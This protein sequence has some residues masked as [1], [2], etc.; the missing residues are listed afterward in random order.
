MYKAIASL[1][2]CLIAS[3]ANAQTTD[4]IYKTQPFGKIDI[5]DLQM[6]TC[7]FEKDANA[8][9]L[10]SKSNVYFNANY[11]IVVEI[12]KRI[13]IFNDNGKDYANVRIEYYG[14]DRSEFISGIQGETI[15]LVNGVPEFTKVDKKQIFSEK[16]DR[17]KSA[18]VFSFPNVKPGSILEYKYTI[19]GNNIGNFPDWYFQTSIPT[20]YS[21]LT[22]NIPDILYY[23]NLESVHQKFVVNKSNSDGSTTKALANVASI[24]D[25]PYMSSL[26]DNCQRI[27][28]QLMSVRP[29]GQRVMTFSDSWKKVGETLI[30]SESFGMQLNRK[31]TGEEA[32]IAKAKALKTDDEKIAYLFNEVKNSMKW[33]EYY[34]KYPEDG[35]GKAWDKKAGNSGEIN[36]ILYH[37]LKKSGVM[38]FPM[39]TSTRKNGRVNPAYPNYY[40]FNNTVAYVPVDSA[41]YYVL[42]ASNK[43]N[44]YNQIPANLL[45]SFGFYM[46]KDQKDYDIKFLQNTTP[47]RQVVLLNGTIKPDG[48]MS[49]TAEVSNFGYNRVAVVTKYK[50]DG[51]KKFMDYL[52]NDD[53]NLKISSIK[54]DGIDVDTLPLTHKV[55]FDLDLTGSDDKYIYFSPNMLSSVKLNP[56]LAENRYTDIDFG[57][58][59][60]YYINCTF[61]VPAGFKVDVLPKNATMSL[62]DKSMSFKRIAAEEDGTIVIRFIIDQKKSIYFKENYEEFHEFYKKMYEMLNEQIVLKKS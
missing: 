11:D 32:I 10:F 9:F 39:I 23:K 35:I 58:R 59:S 55:A 42:D 50:K 30:E 7:D 18:T 12:H 53:N 27:L 3:F 44:I 31:I 56:F 26:E 15:N 13:K 8:E 38:V 21:E 51:E 48:K 62:A 16:I 19:V 33:N 41:K 46:N 52:V 28:F 20:R 61:K 49:G 57:Y 4:V 29:A 14:G 54:F 5:A 40:Q 45:N 43:F 22:T 47:V 60:N 24:P 2:L 37:L 25:E 6:K 17:S 1:L 36:I 34:S